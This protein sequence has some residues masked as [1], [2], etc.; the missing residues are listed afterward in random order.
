MIAALFHELKEWIRFFWG[1]SSPDKE[2]VFYSEH[3]G[4]MPSFEGL[5]HQ[6]TT[7]HNQP[8]SYVTS[9]KDDP[10]LQM[11]NSLLR[12]FYFRKLLPFFMLFV[13]CK[14][15]LMTLTD[16]NHFYLKRS[17]HNPH[18]VYVF[19]ALVSTHMMY[20]YGAFDH[21]DSLLCVGPHH[22]EEIR[23]D[24]QIRNLPAKKLVEAGYYRLERIYRAYQERKAAS[25]RQQAVS[26][27]KTILIAPSWG[28]QHLLESCGEKLI[29]LLL[30]AGYRVIVRPH[31]ETVKRSPELLAALKKNFSSQQNFE[32]EPSVAT[33][34]SLLQA[35]LLISDCSGIMLEYALG[36]ERP[37]LSIAVPPKIK[38]EKF[39]YLTIEP[40]ELQ[41]RKQ[42]GKV[43]SP[44]EIE[45]VPSLVSEL[46]AQ[47]ESYGKKIRTLREKWVF[48]FGKSSEVGAGYVLGLLKQ[49][50]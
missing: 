29:E 36:T 23:K 5:L 6:L 27:K 37:V 40:L 16:L 13:R 20:R 50:P 30:A 45:K 42:F 44:E 34:D 21:Y 31:P 28:K 48:N 9:Q 3:G 15:L 18:Y 26:N 41:L 11:Q 14:V 8:L 17:I 7:V 24:E 43:I 35:D 38:N 19:H 46:I 39:N 4:Y 12:T 25:S 1:T 49:T 22:L 47:K 33:D 2:I 10:V 32:L